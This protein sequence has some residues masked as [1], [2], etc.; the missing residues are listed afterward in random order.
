MLARSERVPDGLERG[1]VVGVAVR[2]VEE[3]E[4]RSPMPPPPMLRAR[5]R[6]R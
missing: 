5:C 4:H 1:V 6:R 3:V 2:E